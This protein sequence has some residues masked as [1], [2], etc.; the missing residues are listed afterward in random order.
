MFRSIVGKARDFLQS[1]IHQQAMLPKP[2]LDIN[3]TEFRTMRNLMLRVQN[4]AKEIKHLQDK[5]LAKLKQQLADTKSM[6]K[7]KEQKAL[8]A[9]IEEIEHNL[10]QQFDQFLDMLKTEDYPDVQEFTRT[11]RQMKAV[12]E[13]Y[14]QDLAQWE[15]QIGKTRSPLERESVRQKPSCTTQNC[16]QRIT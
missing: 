1:L 4:K 6:F 5:V 11:F 10:K 3:M 16:T 14:K 7:G 8:T 9:K 2:T 12:V 13:Q 15:C